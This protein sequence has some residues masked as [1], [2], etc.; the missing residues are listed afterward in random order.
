MKT[1]SYGLLEVGQ[2]IACAFILPL[3]TVLRLLLGCLHE[4]E[5]QCGQLVQVVIAVALRVVLTCVRLH[6][7]GQLLLPVERV[8][9]VAACAMEAMSTPAVVEHRLLDLDAET[10]GPI[11]AVPAG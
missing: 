10:G 1:S 8:L 6:S 5:P 7:S 3:L 4:A 11:Q 2:L 9:V